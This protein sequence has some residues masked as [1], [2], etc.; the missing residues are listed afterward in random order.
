MS[1]FLQYLR[2]ISTVFCGIACVLLIALW[3]RSYW[4][5]DSFGHPRRGVI[6]NEFMSCRG[7]VTL[8]L[9]DDSLTL[10]DDWSFRT[11]AVSSSQHRSISDDFWIKNRFQWNVTGGC[12]WI[13]FPH[14]FAFALFAA[15]AVASWVRWRFC[16]RTLLIATTLVAVALG[17]VVWLR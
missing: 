15:I 1:R 9:D 11:S 12:D 13:R 7:N 5:I 8:E 6:P 4:R 2:I 3:V 14:W 17:L 10:G 16:L